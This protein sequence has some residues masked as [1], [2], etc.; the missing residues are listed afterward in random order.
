MAEPRGGLTPA[1][2][3]VAR[4]IG[5]Q[6]GVAAAVFAL[7]A[8]F[9]S[10]SSSDANWQGTLTVQRALVD[11]AGNGGALLVPPLLA[12]APML[13]STYL[14]ELLT[15]LV[16]LALCQYA[17]R[18]AAETHRDGDMGSVAGAWVM[19]ISGAIWLVITIVLALFT[20]LDGTFAWFL[21]TIA[22][23][24]ISNSV[25]AA[26]VYVSAPD[27]GFVAL[28]TLALLIQNGLGFGFALGAGSLA[29]RRGATRPPRAARPSHGNQVSGA[30]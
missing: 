9:I 21:A 2:R 19:L 15:F 12:L 14:A 29:G 6:L 23:L 13:L 10:G 18:L 8:A 22:E 28:H 25:S 26:H 11:L 7:L 4:R 20:Q 24:L 30:P 17:G 27:A 3:A 16:A 5:R 1:Q